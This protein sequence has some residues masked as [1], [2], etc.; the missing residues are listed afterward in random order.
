KEARIASPADKFIL[1][2]GVPGDEAAGDMAFEMVS[3]SSWRGPGFTHNWN[4]TWSGTN[5]WT[6]DDKNCP[7]NMG[8]NFLFCD[9]HAKWFSGASTQNDDI[10]FMPL[11]N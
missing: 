10:R 2:D 6:P 7:H 8:S 3:G 5:P 4:R 1:W 9:G 11:I